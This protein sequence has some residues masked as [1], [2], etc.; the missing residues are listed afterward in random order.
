MQ[1]ELWE[2]YRAESSEQNFTALLNSYAK[3]IRR[4]AKFLTQKSRKT[5]PG[6]F[7]FDDIETEVRRGFANAIP[8]WQPDSGAKFTT[9]ATTGAKFKVIDFVREIHPLSR[10][11]IE[12]GI[13]VDSLNELRCDRKQL[14]DFITPEVLQKSPIE[15]DD[16]WQKIN[17]YLQPWPK[18][19]LLINLIHIKQWNHAAC[20]K[21][22]NVKKSR[23]KGLVH[24]AIT[25]L[26]EHASFKELTTPN[27]QIDV[28]NFY[29]PNICKECDKTIYSRGY[30]RRHYQ[31]H[32]RK[33]HF[34]PKGSPLCHCG[35][36]MKVEQQECIQCTGIHAHVER[37]KA[38]RKI[39][40]TVRARIL[41]ANK[42]Y[43]AN[44]GHKPQTAEQKRKQAI[45]RRRYYDKNKERIIA[46]KKAFRRDHREEWLAIARAKRKANA[47]KIRAWH[48]ANY[49]KN[50]DK[51]LAQTKKTRKRRLL[52]E[53]LI[54]LPE[55]MELSATG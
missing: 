42:R 9:Y 21:Y 1:E 38:L 25:K 41:A 20:A 7:T 55:T 2:R 30:C 4:V 45:I 16:F 15:P 28:F 22:F 36:R 53:K 26:R 29:I 43:N 14:L 49:A 24:E 23:I 50:R 46:E 35:N 13:H 40:P 54:H 33:G 6:P 51:I 52:R 8:L 5:Y 39:D 17:N 10:K 34:L 3:D 18:L 32:Y 44:R 12:D 47:V 19:Q 27:D 37:I 31:I 11:Q 48:R